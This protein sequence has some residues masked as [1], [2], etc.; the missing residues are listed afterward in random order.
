MKMPVKRAIKLIRTAA[1]EKNREAIFMMYLAYLP[2]MTKDNKMT[3]Q[4]FYDSAVVDVDKLDIRKAEDIMND[5][6]KIQHKFKGVV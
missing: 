2:F 5:I 6:A 1:K 3:F 4:E